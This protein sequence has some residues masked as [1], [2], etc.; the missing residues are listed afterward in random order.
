MRGCCLALP[1]Q[2]VNQ[3]SHSAKAVGATVEPFSAIGCQSKAAGGSGC[4][5]C[6]W[7]SATQ[8]CLPNESGAAGSGLR[9]E[10]VTSVSLPGPRRR[11]RRDP[12]QGEST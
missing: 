4:W 1:Q 8:R 9:L 5:R 11:R 7:R 12:G 3:R 10:V 6:V 2:P